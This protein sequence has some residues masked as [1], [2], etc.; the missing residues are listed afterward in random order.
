M[1]KLFGLGVRRNNRTGFSLTELI[2]TVAIASILLTLALP[3]LSAIVVNNQLSATAN[4][5]LAA[6]NLTR[7]EAIKR[8]QYVVM[9]KTGSN[10]EDGWQIFVDLKRDSTESK[11][12]FDA[13]SDILLK[14]YPGLNDG[15]TLRGNNSRFQSYVGY[16]PNGSSNGMGSFAL[17]KNQQL[18]GTKLLIVNLVGRPRIA[19]DS[20]RDGIPEKDSG[21]DITSCMSGF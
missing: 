14:T 21:Q 2:A 18:Q 1:S 15:Y 19:T 8:G 9:R 3:S 17:C 4:E 5:F 7:S 10:W 12:A 16:Q 6:L 13:D 11:N 20:D